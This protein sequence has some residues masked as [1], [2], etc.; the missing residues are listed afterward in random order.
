[1]R[2]KRVSYLA[3]EPIDATFGTA[4][5]DCGEPALD[6]W[7]TRYA[8]ANEVTGRSRT[9]VVRQRDDLNVAAY[10]CLSTAV[11]QYGEATKRATQGLPRDEPVPAILLGRLAV[12]LKHQS[13]GLGKALLAD[14]VRRTFVSIASN[15]GVRL[16]V[17]H[18]KHE[19]ARD[20]Y[21]RWQFEPSPLSP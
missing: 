17:V 8:L 18:A 16:L 11:V 13:R 1:M 15:A 2:S 3:P 10:Y 12:D 5:F 6:R 4:Q 20:F 14:A 7:L 19:R 9:F 21:L